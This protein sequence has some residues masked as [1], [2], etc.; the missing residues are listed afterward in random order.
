MATGALSRS[1]LSYSAASL[2]RDSARDLLKPFS[3]GVMITPRRMTSGL[4]IA[5]RRLI[6]LPPSSVT[7]ADIQGAGHLRLQDRGSHSGA[8]GPPARSQVRCAACAVDASQN[9]SQAATRAATGLTGRLARRCPRRRP[10]DPTSRCFTVQTPTPPSAGTRPAR[11][12]RR[13]ARPAP[14]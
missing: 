12:H 7:C 1:C 11:T 5:L 13:A 14:A 3:Y 8:F 6:G 9:A 4:D 2:G 10:A